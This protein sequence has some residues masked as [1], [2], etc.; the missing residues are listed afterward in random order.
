MEFIKSLFNKQ[1]QTPKASERSSSFNSENPIENPLKLLEEQVSY[2]SKISY[3]PLPTTQEDLIVQQ[4]NIMNILR[5]SIFLFDVVLL[6]KL[7][8]QSFKQSGSINSNEL[9]KRNVSS[10]MLG[11]GIGKSNSLPETA[12]ETHYWSFISKYFRFPSVK[13][14]TLYEGF[15]ND[16]ERGYAWICI[17]ILE[18]TFLD[19]IKEIYNQKF[20]SKFYQKNSIISEKKSEILTILEEL[21]RNIIMFKKRNVEIYKE[22]EKY[23][24]FIEL[25]EKEGF[26]DDPHTPLNKDK[27][28]VMESHYMYTPSNFYGVNNMNRKNDKDLL[29]SL[30]QSQVSNPGMNQQEKGDL[31][32]LMSFMNNDDTLIFND[33]DFL[34]EEPDD[35]YAQEKNFP[36]YTRKISNSSYYNNPEKIGKILT[37]EDKA[38]QSDNYQIAKFMDFQQCMRDDYFTFNKATKKNSTLFLHQINDENKNNSNIPQLINLPFEKKF[39]VTKKTDKNVFTLKDKIFINNREVKMTNSIC[40]YLNHFYNKGV[41]Y[42][43]DT[44]ITNVKPITVRYIFFNKTVRI[45]KFPMSIL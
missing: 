5:K 42:R 34:E 10:P 26:D 15:Q 23:K 39:R 18:N 4:T 37:S 24:E 14:V 19:A 21:T 44:Q 45:S 2:L 9:N 25:E 6:D 7:R 31:N 13:F 1:K 29:S 11:L 40:F 12:H 27:I 22:Y 41:F 32:K 33:N 36:K 16:K 38:R 35:G 3:S 28:P 8:G 30:Y 17:S 43:F 20:D